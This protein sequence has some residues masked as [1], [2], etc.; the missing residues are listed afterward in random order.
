[1]IKE[2]YGIYVNHS[3]EGS[4]EDIWRRGYTEGYTRRVREEKK[5]SAI[6]SHLIEPKNLS[7][8]SVFDWKV[9]AD[10]IEGLFTGEKIG[11][12]AKDFDISDKSQTE[13]HSNVVYFANEQR[14]V[15]IANK[16]PRIFM[17]GDYTV[18]SS[19]YE[20]CRYEAFFPIDSFIRLLESNKDMLIAHENAKIENARKYLQGNLLRE[21]IIMQIEKR[22]SA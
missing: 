6:N 5:N 12:S 20:V 14:L 16:V 22:G 18:K 21:D 4:Q 11:Y 9:Y 8:L 7:H 15:L 19:Q 13:F 2:T 17:L 10:D 3:E 1:M